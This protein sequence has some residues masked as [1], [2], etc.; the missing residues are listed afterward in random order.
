M[1]VFSSVIA[2]VLFTGDRIDC[3]LSQSG[4]SHHALQ[5]P[6]IVVKLSKVDIK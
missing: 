1:R 3:I 2:Q 6:F 4:Q 5:Y